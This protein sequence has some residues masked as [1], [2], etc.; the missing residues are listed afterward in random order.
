MLGVL[1]FRLSRN[2]LATAA[3]ITPAALSASVRTMSAGIPASSR[4]ISPSNSAVAAAA[5]NSRIT[6]DRFT[7]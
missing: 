1:L 2:P 4:A 7:R 5:I 6:T 3:N